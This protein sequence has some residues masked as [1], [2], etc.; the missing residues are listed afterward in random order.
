MTVELA[1][2]KLKK[3]HK[4]STIEQAALVYHSVPGREGNL[5][6][7]LG[8][9][10]V[11]LQIEGIFYGATAKRDLEKLRSVYK[12]GKP[13]D[14]LAEITGQAYFGQVILDQFQVDQSAQYPNQFSYILIVSEYAVSLKSA[15]IATDIADVDAN[16]LAE[17]ENF[18]D[19]ATLPDLL[20]SVP[21]INN[22]I[23]PL[24]NALAD[25]E[26]ATKTLSTATADL[27]SLFGIQ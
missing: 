27:K 20:G 4:I 14:F 6:Q 19:I 10:S 26:K 9:D 22:P 13:V 2:I 15:A 7:N 17:A 23:E 24:S 1:G 5:V 18:M 21:E 16:I 11:Q 3:V 8:R 25:V 12:Q